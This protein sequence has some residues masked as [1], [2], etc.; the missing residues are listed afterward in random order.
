MRLSGT[1]IIFALS[2]AFGSLSLSAQQHADTVYLS[3]LYTTHLIFSNDILYAD[4]SNSQDVAAKIVEQSNNMLAVKARSPFTSPTSISALESNGT[5]H[6]FIVSYR[7]HPRD[8][9][10][11]LRVEKKQVEEAPKYQS[12]TA[13]MI[14][15]AKKRSGKDSA[16]SSEGGANVSPW[17]SGSAPLLQEVVELPQKLFH[18][19]SKE[20]DIELLC[21]DISSYSDITYMT[22]SVRNRSGISYDISD[23]TFVIESKKAGR[24]TVKYDRPVFPKSRY[25]SLSVG[26]GG[27]SRMAY[28][29]DKMTLSKDQVLRVY[30]YEVGG[31][32]N[33]VVT[34]DTDDINKARRAI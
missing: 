18:I 15:G 8:L 20:Y 26:P 9:V 21:E 7:E 14:N 17:K 1:F 30:L 31:Q 11:D 28:S 27:Y 22:L 5:M 13:E 23:A 2:V 33:L 34:L 19:Y 24:R 10:L 32:R 16:S 12:R 29:F 4:L 6:T 25:G 3:T